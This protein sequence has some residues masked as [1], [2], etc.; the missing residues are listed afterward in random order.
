VEV[1]KK[2]NGVFVGIDTN[3]RVGVF[4]AVSAAEWLKAV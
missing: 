1:G 2:L 4:V 3:S